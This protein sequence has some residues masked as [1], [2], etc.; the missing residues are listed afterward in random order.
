MDTIS[1]EMYSESMPHCDPRI[2]HAPGECQVC[3]AHPDLQKARHKMMINYTGYNG[4]GFG[5][6]PADFIRKDNHSIWPGNRP[7]RT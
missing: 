4:E 5:P 2:L 1:E 7:W 3:D 6:C